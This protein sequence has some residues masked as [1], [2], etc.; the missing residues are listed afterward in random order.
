MP[1]LEIGE[2]TIEVDDSFLKLSPEDQEA[3][4]DEVIGSISSTQPSG[5]ETAAANSLETVSPQEPIR[6]GNIFPL[7]YDPNQDKLTFNPESGLLGDIIKGI[8][9]P[10]RAIMG[11]IPSYGPDGNIHP[12]MIDEAMGLA[13]LAP[14]QGVVVAGK[15]AIKPA[16]TAAAKNLEE[17]RE[18]GI[19]LSRGQA[20]RDFKDQTFEQDALHGV[21]G[22]GAQ[23]QLA[24]HRASQGEQVEG[25]LQRTKDEIAP[26]QSDDAFEMAE[27][28]GQAVKKR[29]D[30]LHKEG[31]S[32]YQK[33]D[34]LGGAIGSG[35]AVQGLSRRI[36]NKVG[37]EGGL[38]GTRVADIYPSTA[39]QMKKLQQFADEAAKTPDQPIDWRRFEN[40]RKSIMRAGGADDDK[41]LLGAMKRELD[42]WIKESIDAGLISGEP[43]FLDSLVRARGVW[44][45][46]LKIKKSETGII[47]DMVSGKATSAHIANWL[48]G[49]SKVGARA[50]SANVAKE[51]K[52]I[53]GENHPAIGE[54]RR[55]VMTRL[56]E[57]ANTG[58]VKGTT[59]LA[60]DIH[61]LFRGK[62]RDLAKELYGSQ[63]ADKMIRL[64]N[65]IKNIAP[66]PEATN[67][68][69]SG[70]TI[71][72]KLQEMI[73]QAA[74][75]IGYSVGDFT[76]MLGGLLVSPAGS[77]LS[78]RKAAKMVAK[79]MPRAPRL[80]NPGSQSI[81]PSAGAFFGT[82]RSNKGNKT[83]RGLLPNEV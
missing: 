1:V 17:A 39:L 45:D 40:V 71:G 59:A 63:A 70:F 14:A 9:A 22:R 42:S 33:A 20:S 56:F 55:G 66:E 50:D 13:G 34:E 61:T 68:P 16:I 43:E 52:K 49:A 75:I 83:D 60:N 79:P 2:H 18:F 21:K 6:R 36:F 67:P 11:K 29:A 19:D 82:Q 62:G 3:F 58:E 64:A 23:R 8:R 24:Q 76:G 72:R 51:I 74:P 27:G 10:G 31:T 46:Y 77:A 12:Q 53:L 73:K 25:A 30:D 15:S 81:L 26:G 7:D 28:V 41:R 80:S 48:Y 44:A 54:L 32:L 69:K 47:R 78:R 57:N 38:D 5:A 35:R 4:V 65:A 37:E